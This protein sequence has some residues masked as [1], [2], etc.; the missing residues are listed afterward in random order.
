VVIATGLGLF[1]AMCE[2]SSDHDVEGLADEQDK[3]DWPASEEVPG[4]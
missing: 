3:V 2:V 4:I 1:R